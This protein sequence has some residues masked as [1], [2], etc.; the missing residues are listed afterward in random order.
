MIDDVQDELLGLEAEVQEASEEATSQEETNEPSPKKRKGPCH[1]LS[2]YIFPAGRS[3]MLT[4]PLSPLRTSV[5]LSIFWSSCI[6][7][8]PGA[9]E[10][11]ANVHSTSDCKTSIFTGSTMLSCSTESDRTY[12]LPGRQVW[13]FLSSVKY[14]SPISYNFRVS[15]FRGRGRGEK[16]W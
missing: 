8:I 4:D 3:V 2:H 6:T 15:N 7:T 14:K 11:M 10:L 13:A 9:V 1:T 16:N 12:K 5:V